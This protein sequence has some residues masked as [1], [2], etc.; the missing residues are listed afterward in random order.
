M[1]FARRDM[2]RHSAMGMLA[3]ASDGPAIG[4]PSDGQVGHRGGLYR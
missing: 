3:I 4:A 2:L 1:E